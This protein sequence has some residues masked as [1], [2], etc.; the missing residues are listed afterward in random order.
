M[1][2]LSRLVSAWK[3]Q[4]RAEP[5]TV[6]VPSVVVA[7]G[8]VDVLPVVGVGR[9]EA[10][11]RDPRWAAYLPGS[12]GRVTR[13][14]GWSRRGPRQR[15]LLGRIALGSLFVGRD[16]TSWSVDEIAAAHRALERS[17]RWIEREAMRWRAGLAIGILDTYF[18][19]D[20]P[21][22]ETVEVAFGPEGAE[23]GPLEAHAELKILAS[24]SRAAASLGFAD[25]AELAAEARGRV[26]CDHAVWVLHLRQGGRS[27]A[28]PEVESGLPGVDLAACYARESSFPEPLPGPPFSDPVT[29]VH[30]LLHLFGASDKYGGSLARYGREEVSERDVMVLAHESLSRLRVDRLTA[31]EVGWLDG[32]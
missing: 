15:P 19:A 11:T 30:E 26:A 16:G 12:K 13:Q 23:V 24:A 2:W 29:F 31:R 18:V 5:A 3:G 4:E 20:D 14:P 6:A 32:R 8:Q 27:L 25:M 10:L 21:E 1:G 28:I 9:G 17:G 7:D 22:V